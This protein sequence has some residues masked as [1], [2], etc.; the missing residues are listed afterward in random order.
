MLLSET[1]RVALSEPV[2]AGVKLTLIVQLPPAATVLLQL[3]V[4]IKSLALAPVTVM[5]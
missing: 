3:F 2:V 5:P 4:C 1:L